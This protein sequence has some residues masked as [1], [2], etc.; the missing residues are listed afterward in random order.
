VEKLGLERTTKR[1]AKEA[2]PPPP[3]ERSL[4]QETLYTRLCGSWE[5]GVPSPSHPKSA[6]DEAEAER[7]R[8][9]ASTPRASITPEVYSRLCR[10]PS[11]KRTTYVSPQFGQSLQRK[12]RQR[13]G[14]APPARKPVAEAAPAPEAAPLGDTLAELLAEEGGRA[15]GAGEAAEEAAACGEAEAAGGEA[16]AADGAEAEGAVAASAAEGA[17][18]DENRVWVDAPKEAFG[19]VNLASAQL[20][21]EAAE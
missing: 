3:A 7:A 2:Q 4:I 20:E 11:A 12:P 21:D 8:S 5:P 14:S 18:E 13:P 6:R 17:S 9:V 10:P 19:E 15:A 1:A 16:A